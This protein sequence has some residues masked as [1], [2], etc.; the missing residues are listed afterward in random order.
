MSSRRRL[1]RRRAN[2]FILTYYPF[3]VVRIIFVVGMKS[4]G[5]APTFLLA[6]GYEQVGS[7]V[8][9]LVGDHAAA[10]RVELQLPHT[11]VCQASPAEPCPYDHGGTTACFG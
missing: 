9:T 4:Y 8:A 6:T 7:V 2:F 11:G 10:A 5:R 3:N 1:H